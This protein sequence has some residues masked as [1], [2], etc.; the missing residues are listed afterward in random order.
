MARKASARTVLN[1]KALNDI[2]GALADGMG[3]LGAAVIERADPPDAEPFGKGLVTTG[4]W[5]VWAGTKKVLGSATKPRTERLSRTGLTML[6]GFGFPG[7]FQE[8]GT[9]N[10]PAQPFLTPAVMAEFPD[11]GG[12]LKRAFGKVSRG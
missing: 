11:A 3:M 8:K 6:V 12:H 2:A 5:G 9:I 7:R 4:D 1:R 10:H